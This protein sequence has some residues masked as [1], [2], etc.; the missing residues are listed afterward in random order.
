MSHGSGDPTINRYTHVSVI[1]LALPPRWEKIGQVLIKR[2]QLEQTT[3][4]VL[5]VGSDEERAR[6]FL[7]EHID[8]ELNLGVQAF[9]SNTNYL[10]LSDQ[11]DVE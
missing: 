9:R 7:M 11:I 1:A 6:W 5:R 3:T 10:C 2:A 8:S 4:G